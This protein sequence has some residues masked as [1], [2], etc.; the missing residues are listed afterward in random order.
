[1]GSIDQIVN[2]PGEAN[3]NALKN[4]KEYLDLPQENDPQ[5]RLELT[6]LLLN[7]G[8][9]KAAIQKQG[10]LFEIY[11]VDKHISHD[12]ILFIQNKIS[13]K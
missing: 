5:K 7:D 12:E 10:K 9:D 3:R 6:Y 8:M 2:D 13:Q 1:M 4:L 11:I